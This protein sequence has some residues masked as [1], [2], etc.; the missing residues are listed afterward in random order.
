MG[1]LAVSLVMATAIATPAL[2]FADGTTSQSTDV[3]IQSVTPEPGGDNLSFSVPTQIP[4]VAKADGTMLVASAENL[5]IKNKSV[6]PIHVVSMTVTEQ[7]PFKLVADVTT[8]TDANAFQFTINGTKAAP[9]VNTSNNV[10]WSMG[11]AGS[12]TDTIP[13]VITDAKIAHVTTDI[14]TPQKAATIT[15]TVASGA[16]HAAQ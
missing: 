8:G 1:A 5:Q 3:T 16:A 4:F 2:A 7:S 13:L 14:T 11:H 12:E 10:A 9:S 6:F 15:W